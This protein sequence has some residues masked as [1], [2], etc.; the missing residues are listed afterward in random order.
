MEID[1]H[2]TFLYIFFSGFGFGLINIATVISLK[3]TFD[4]SFA[5]VFSVSLMTANVG[6]AVLPVILAYLTDALGYESA[7]LVYSG[8]TG[9]L[10]IS[11]LLLPVSKE[12]RTEESSAEK[13][14]L[15]EEKQNGAAVVENHVKDNVGKLVQDDDVF[16]GYSEYSSI[17]RCIDS[18][19]KLFTIH[20]ELMLVLLIEAIYGY[21]MS[22]WSIFLV[23]YC[24]S[25]GFDSKTAVWLSSVGGLGGLLARLYCAFLYHT[26][27][28]NVIVGLALPGLLAATGY[29][30]TLFLII[31]YSF[32]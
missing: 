26:G 14:R 9:I 28:M 18:L 8:L 19:I 31:L 6:I 16:Q 24:E 3:E 21:G 27:R 4:D 13:D 25:V 29:V 17:L 30:V 20:P 23:P 12:T 22:S 15:L 1:Q 5:T 2:F 11:G 32:L 10:I 7:M